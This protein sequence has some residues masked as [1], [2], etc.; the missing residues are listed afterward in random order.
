MTRASIVHV[1]AVDMFPDFVDHSLAPQDASWLETHLASCDACREDLHAYEETVAMV[2]GV[3]RRKAPAWACNP[4][5]GP[6]SRCFL[7]T[8]VSPSSRGKGPAGARPAAA[9]LRS[10]C[11]R[12][13]II[14]PKWAAPTPGWRWIARGGYTPGKR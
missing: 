10:W 5:C 8:C 2:R 3:E 14:V 4:P 12:L 7:F 1:R 11:P 13:T 9:T 6:V